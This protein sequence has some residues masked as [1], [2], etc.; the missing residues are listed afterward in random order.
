MRSFL[1]RIR[2]LLIPENSFRERVYHKFREVIFIFRNDT[3]G[4]FFRARG[5]LRK[6]IE[7]I[8]RPYPYPQWI[9]DNQRSS[10]EL[11]TQRRSS[12]EFSYKPVFSFTTPV[13]NPPVDAL[14]DTLDSVLNQ[15]YPFWELCIANGSTEEEVNNFLDAHASRDSR[16]KV[17]HLPKNEGISGNTNAAIDM[18]LGEFIVLMDHDDLLD[19][20]LLFESASWLNRD[21][22]IDI[23][24]YDEDK[25]SEDGTTRKDPFFKPDWSPEMFLSANFLTHP[26]V[27]VTLVREVGGLN[28]EMDGTQDWDLLLRCV[29]RTDRIVHIP[30]VLYHWRQVSG[31]TAGQFSAKSYVFDR[32]KK[33]VANFLER[34]GLADIEVEFQYPGYMRSRWSTSG[35]MVSIII[36]SRNNLKL[37]KKCIR[38]IVEKTNYPAYEILIVDNGSDDPDTLDYYKSLGSESKIRVL[39][40]NEQFNYSRANNIGAQAAKGD[41]LLFLNNDIE[42]LEPDWLQEMVQ[43]VELP[44]IGI[45][46]AK[47]L[48]PDRTIQHAGVII[49]MEGH[50]SHIFWGAYPRE[51]TIM[52]SVDWYRNYLAVTG[53]CMMMTRSIYQELK[54]FDEE[55]ELVFS[56]IEIC[57]RAIDLGYRIVYTPYARLIHHEGQS[58]G[59]NIPAADVLVGAEHFMDWVTAGDPYFNQNLSY[60]HRMPRLH[61][62]GD[63]TRIERLSRIIDH[64]RG[65]QELIQESNE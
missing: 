56:D 59:S 16:I 8:R 25:I 27:R 50:A 30:E 53:A 63:E 22:S 62:K 23:I 35:R 51:S 4:F 57:L 47:L 40:Y 12:Q 46:G 21:K 34:K 58:R 5:R 38:S 36:P 1:L 15:T 65:K 61:R 14:K 18:A 2:F 9:I 43:W 33:C 3:L 13:Y 26:I 19:P 55:Y 41:I 64:H 45:V 60:A 44:E 37:I 54:G 42:I 17:N 11:E 29:E 7:L 6:L 32:Q 20:S 49:G 24:Y 28:P 48:Y 10:E 31:S 39:D 52:G